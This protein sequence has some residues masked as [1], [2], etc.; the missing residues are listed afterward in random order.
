MLSHKLSIKAISKSSITKNVETARYWAIIKKH[1]S[2]AGPT[3]TTSSFANVDQ[4]VN[5]TVE[6]Q[7]AQPYCELPKDGVFNL[8]RKFLPGG[9]YYNLDSAQIVKSMQKEHGDIY[10]LPGMMGRP[11]AVVTH[12]PED[13][14]CIYR[15]EGRWPIRPSSS[16]LRYH[17]NVLRAEFYNG[18]E[19]TIATQGEQWGSFRSIVN[20]LL[21]QSKNMKNYLNK[22]AQVNQE[23]VERIRLVRNPETLEMPDDFEETLQRWT[24]ESVSVVALDKQLGLLRENSANSE[25]ALKLFSALTDFFTLTFD[26]EYKPSLWRIVSTPKFR[27]LMRAMDDIQNITWKYT[28]E[29]IEKLEA[30][31]RQGIER[32]EREQS[33]LEKLLKIDKKVATVMAMDLLMAGVDT[34]ASVAVG[35]LVC[36]AKNPEKQKKLRQEVLRVLPRKD[37][38][39]TIDAL[40]N[41]PYL[42]ACLKEALRIYPL[43]IGN[44][45]VLHND[46]LLS[47]FRVPKGTVVTMISST[48]L[49]SEEHFPRPLEYIPERWLRMNKEDDQ[50][51]EEAADYTQPLKPSNP[52][53]YLPFSVGPRACVG[54][55]LG[56]LEMELGIARLVRNFHIE[57]NYPTHNI[58]KGMLINMPNVPL[59]FK[60]IDI[61]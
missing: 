21:M 48:A 10:I 9:R 2:A 44:I 33:V 50:S 56:D 24:L 49:H 13:F 55:R 14:E 28:T 57:F 27:R 35:A 31:K 43:A 42:R 51:N 19:G 11:D 32:K 4:Q 20:P 52:F 16:T 17:R 39:F 8:L 15:N 58:F 18:I 60:F 6:W 34:T 7:Q 36:L 26:L 29:V 46:V 5:M 38:D 1:T 30:E 23:L 53:I 37:G 3:S 41:I 61:E 54:H 40:D 25:I 45:R 22:M 47:G 59:K 12:N